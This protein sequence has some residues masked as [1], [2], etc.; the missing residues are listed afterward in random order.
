VGFTHG[1]F[2]MEFFYD[3][4]S[5][6]LGVIEFNPRMAS[7]FS[8]L[9]LRVL[10]IDLHAIALALAHNMDPASLPRCVPSAG[11]AASFVYRSFEPGASVVQPTPARQAALHA[12]FPGA[13]LFGFPKSAS[14]IARDFKWLGSYRYGIVHLAAADARQLHLNCERA[15]ALLGWPAPCADRS[16]GTSPAGSSSAPT[17]ANARVALEPAA[18]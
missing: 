1:L 12:V 4:V 3:D 14:E 7:Q 5:D 8:D 9:Y 2:N 13:L 6:R 18:I 10:G 16:V 15:S 17:E 11:S